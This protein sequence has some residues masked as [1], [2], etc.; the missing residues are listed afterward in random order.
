MNVQISSGTISAISGQAI[1]DI[2][3]D[4]AY[5]TDCNRKIVFWGKSAQRITGWTSAEVIGRNCSDSAATTTPITMILIIFIIF[6]TTAI[7]GAEPDGA[8]RGGFRMRWI[9]LLAV[10]CF[11][12]RRTQIVPSLNCACGV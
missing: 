7:T 6:P 11:R 4:G 2:L 9:A 8:E 12:S 3:P 1:L 10:A 5:I